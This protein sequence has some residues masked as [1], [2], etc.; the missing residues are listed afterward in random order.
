MFRIEDNHFLLLYFAFYRFTASCATFAKYIIL[1]PE[2]HA[3]VVIYHPFFLGLSVF[4]VNN[5]NR[6]FGGV[7]VRPLAFHL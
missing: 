1:Q 6:G 5:H 3:A 2:I 7:V 4:Q